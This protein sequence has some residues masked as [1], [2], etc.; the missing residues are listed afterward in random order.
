M[1]LSSAIVLEPPAAAKAQLQRWFPARSSGGNWKNRKPFGWKE[2]GR[3]DKTFDRNRNL[4][5][6]LWW[7]ESRH[8]KIRVSWISPDSWIFYKGF[9]HSMKESNLIGLDF[10]FPTWLGRKSAGDGG[11]M[12]VWQERKRE[13]KR[14]SESVC[15]HK[16][17]KREGFF[18]CFNDL[19]R[20]GL[21]LE[22]KIDLSPWVLDKGA[23]SYSEF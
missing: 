9:S 16:W 17:G 7:P 3:R 4:I 12:V 15:C 13:D 10:W 6:G 20:L 5:P 11:E 19:E 22:G 23:G 1:T 14:K 8:R 21:F 18:V 2:R